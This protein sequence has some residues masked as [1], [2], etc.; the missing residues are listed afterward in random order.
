M[1]NRPQVPWMS[2]MNCAANAPECDSLRDRWR[3]M[4][5]GET[6]LRQV[7]VVPRFDM[8][9]THGADAVHGGTQATGGA[10]AHGVPTIMEQYLGSSRRVG[11]VALEFPP[12]RGGIG[13]YVSDVVSFL[14][15]NRRVDVILTLTGAPAWD[16][17]RASVRSKPSLSSPSPSAMKSSIAN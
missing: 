11:V 15:R 4:T 12:V 6:R 10:R 9:R 7:Q 3:R 5:R 16:R 8:G 1:G 14:A 17:P 13:A 2:P